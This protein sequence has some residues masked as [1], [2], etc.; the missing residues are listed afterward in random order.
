MILKLKTTIILLLLGFVLGFFTNL[1]LPGWGHNSSSKT[2]AAVQ[3]KELKKKTESTEKAYQTQIENLQDQNID[4]EQTLEVTQ[5]L[6]DQAKQAASKTE[7]KITRLIEPTSISPDFA[8]REIDSTG[9]ANN[10]LDS[11]D[12]LVTQ[13]KKYI[14]ENHLKDSLYENEIQTLDNVVSV[15]NSVIKTREQLYSNLHQLFSQSL[16]SQTSLQNEKLHLQKKF[17]RWRLKNKL[18][19]IGLV[20]LSAVTTHYLSHH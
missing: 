13:A 19:T 9:S 18:E 11:C 5:G 10:N 7:K 12:S 16:E 15:K 4:L 17:K 3:V 14:D 8:A 20:I 2:S 1:F 6:L